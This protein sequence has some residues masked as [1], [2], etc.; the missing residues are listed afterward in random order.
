DGVHGDGARRCLLPGDRDAERSFHAEPL[1]LREAGR[2]GHDDEAAAAFDVRVEPVVDERVDVV[3]GAARIV[4]RPRVS[5]W[6]RRRSSGTIVRASPQTKKESEGEE[7][8]R[9][10]HSRVIVPRQRRGKYV[11]DYSDLSGVGASALISSIRRSALRDS[12]EPREEPT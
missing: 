7:E 8:R 3:L 2:A 12:A 11:T 1:V 5:W 6:W 9:S 10:A 4:A